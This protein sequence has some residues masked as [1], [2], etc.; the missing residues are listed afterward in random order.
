L[1]VFESLGSFLTDSIQENTILWIVTSGIIAGVITQILKFLFENK[2]PEWQKRKAYRI[3]ILKY[4]PPILTTTTKIMYTIKNML[5]NPSLVS[6]ENRKL[7]ILYKFACLFGW[8][9]ILQNETF[10]EQISIPESSTYNRKMATE[11]YQIEYLLMAISEDYTFGSQRPPKLIRSVVLT[12][13]MITVIGELMI[14]KSDNKVK[15]YYT[16][17]TFG[18]F[19]TKYRESDRFRKQFECMNAILTNVQMSRINPQ[20]NMLFVI[21]TQ[22]FILFSKKFIKLSYFSYDWLPISFRKIISKILWLPNTVVLILNLFKFLTDSFR[23]QPYNT[24]SLVKIWYSIIITVMEDKGFKLLRWG[25]FRNIFFRLPHIEKVLLESDLDH[26]KYYTI[27]IK[28]TSISTLHFDQKDSK[29]TLLIDMLFPYFDKRFIDPDV[30]SHIRIYLEISGYVRIVNKFLKKQIA[31]V[32]ESISTYS[33]NREKSKAWNI[34]GMLYSYLIPETYY[35]KGRN[36]SEKETESIHYFEK[37][38][39]EDPTNVEAIVNTGLYY[40]DKWTESV[41]NI[42][43][44]IEFFN[45][46]KELV[47]GDIGL[48]QSNIRLSVLTIT[49]SDILNYLGIAYHAKKNYDYSIECYNEAARYE[50]PLDDGPGV[51]TINIENIKNKYNISQ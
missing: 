2:I 15:D 20:W 36:H 7:D 32:E 42:D 21:Y 12:R 40:L 30:Y 26:L 25:E 8:I 34:I 3:A 31:R 13:N 43:K 4:G 10:V 45:K 35:H 44:S 27:T 14:N 37:S 47:K 39:Q 29:N 46:A 28:P 49:L 18:E 41:Y 1:T 11:Q 38:L 33:S 48:I 9:Q 51:S 19:L 17:L 50:Y 24:I 5:E 22:L 6:E 16:V 23:I